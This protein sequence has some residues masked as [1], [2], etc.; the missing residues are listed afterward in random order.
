MESIIIEAGINYFGN[1]REANRIL[2]Y[3]LKSK[4]KNLTFMVHTKDFYDCQK[5]LGIDFKLNKKFY[6]SAIKKCHKKKKEYW[7]VCL[8]KKYF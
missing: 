5:K 3:F 2:N 6:V 8:S 1:L 7:I 4:F